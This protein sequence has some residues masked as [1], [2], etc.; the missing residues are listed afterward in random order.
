MNRVSKNVMACQIT[1]YW[2]FRTEKETADIIFILQSHFRRSIVHHIVCTALARII[3]SLG[4]VIMAVVVHQVCV[5]LLDGRLITEYSFS[6]SFT[7]CSRVTKKKKKQIEKFVFFSVSPHCRPT[8]WSCGV[9][10]SASSQTASHTRPDP[11]SAC[12]S[13]H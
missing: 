9:S 2:L 12:S 5:F 3:T 11:H 6:D 1:S 13:P 4:H 7:V 10:R 8:D